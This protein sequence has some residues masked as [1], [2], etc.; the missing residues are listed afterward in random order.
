MGILNRLLAT[1]NTRRLRR[2][3]STVTPRFFYPP[4]HKRDTL[5]W[6]GLTMLRVALLIGVCILTGCATVPSPSDRKVQADALAQAAGWHAM[7]IKSPPFQLQAYL[8]EYAKQ[9]SA[10]TVYIE[11]D[12]FAWSSP[13]TPSADPTPVNPLALRLAL[14]QAKGNAVYLGRACQYVEAERT[15]CPQRYWTT[16]RFAPEVIAATSHAI[17]VLKQQFGANRLTL[18]GYS[19]GAAVAA[20]LAVERHDVERLITV[21]GNLD[22]AAWTALHG[23]DPLV[24]SLNPAALADKLV[25]LPQIHFVGENDVVIS[26]S[27]AYRWPLALR[28]PENSNIHVITSFSHHCCWVENWEQL[29]S[30]QRPN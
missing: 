14:V 7:L 15:A 10:L 8:P 22:H 16:A 28:G 29:L 11:G 18:V 25:N 23:L 9:E 27:L 2:V 3:F 1:P 12:G 17:N 21:A 4:T 24:D 5:F 26:P 20:L 6:S 13:S 19:G 30:L